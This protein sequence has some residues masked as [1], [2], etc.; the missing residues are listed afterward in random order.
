VR[1]QGRSCST[2]F[3]RKD[4]EGLADRACCAERVGLARGANGE[5]AE[6]EAGSIRE[7]RFQ[8]SEVAA[9]DHVDIGG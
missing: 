1:P 7:G 8:E 5:V 3:D 6:W 9:E 2:A 4:L